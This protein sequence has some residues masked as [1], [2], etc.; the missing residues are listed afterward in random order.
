VVCGTGIAGLAA[1]LGL[2][3][4]GLASSGLTSPRPHSSDGGYAITLLGPKANVPPARAD[5]YHPRVYAVSSSSQAFLA[6]LGVWDMLDASRVTPVEGME[7]YGD[8]DGY[9]NLNA[10]QA[11]HTELAWIIESSEIE[12]VLHQALRMF[13]VAW[14]AERFD[15]LENHRVV[16]DTGR[17]LEADLLIGADGA[18]SA[19]RTAAGIHPESTAYGHM[20]LVTH[21]TA[22]LPHQNVAFQWFTGDTVL[23]LLPMP[24]TADGPQVSMVWSLPDARAQA[25]LAMSPSEQATELAR[26][27]A[28]AT[29]GRLGNLQ[30]RSALF[31]FPLVLERSDMVAPGVALVGDAAHR[32]HPLAGQGLNLGLADVEELIRVLSTKETY[33]KP[34]DLRVLRRYRRARA[35]SLLAMRIATHGLQRLFAVQAAPIVWARNIGMHCVD[36]L[37][38]LKRRLIEGASGH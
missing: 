3:R 35:E 21:L 14:H 9:V 16:T 24:D 1:A 10:W 6:R 12:R 30:V 28:V 5:I 38:F 33:R 7:I 36:R 4:C 27:L 2:A 29:G 18:Q 32:V 8:G 25:L 31:G 11:A 23:A 19:V 15:R 26:H 37:P 20:G 34:G 17:Q 13:G 22:E